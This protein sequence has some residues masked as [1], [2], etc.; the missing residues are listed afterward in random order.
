[1]DHLG[2]GNLGPFEAVNK[3]RSYTATLARLCGAQLV[4]LL[5][6]VNL[7]PADKEKVASK[8]PGLAVVGTR[9]ELIG[10]SP[11]LSGREVGMGIV[12]SS[13]NSEGTEGLGSEVVMLRS[14]AC[15]I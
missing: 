10:I 6:R 14:L 3:D 9:K 2:D 4:W 15:R 7:L 5:S 11:Y 12:T 13:S 1:L 8:E